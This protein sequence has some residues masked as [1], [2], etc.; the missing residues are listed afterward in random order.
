MA[1]HS[2]ANSIR[3]NSRGWL[4]KKACLAEAYGPIPELA[5]DGRG[6]S[7]LIMDKTNV[8]HSTPLGLDGM[9]WQMRKLSQSLPDKESASTSRFVQISSVVFQFSPSSFLTSSVSISSAMSKWKGC[10]TRLSTIFGG[11]IRETRQSFGTF[12]SLAFFNPLVE[13]LEWHLGLHC[14]H[15]QVI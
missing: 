11:K 12:A 7:K 10:R 15:N 6:E 14:Y 2:K 13:N 5:W 8:L 1:S 9:A 4:K 3:A